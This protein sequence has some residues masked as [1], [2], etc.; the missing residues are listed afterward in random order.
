MNEK[1][2]RT[3]YKCRKRIRDNR[4]FINGLSYVRMYKRG[5]INVKTRAFKARNRGESILYTL[6]VLCHTG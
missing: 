1:R 3:I 5:G 4:T 6:G 2:E